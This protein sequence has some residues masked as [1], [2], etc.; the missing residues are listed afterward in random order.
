MI[1]IKIFI[2]CFLFF[3]VC[4]CFKGIS[5]NS[6][7]VKEHKRIISSNELT[8]GV[9]HTNEIIYNYMNQNLNHQNI[10]YIEMDLSFL[11]HSFSLTCHKSKSLT[12]GK[13]TLSNQVLHEQ[14][15]GKNLIGAINGDFF[16]IRNG[17][18]TCAN[19][20]NHEIYST[21]L[22]EEEELLRPCFAIQ[23][24]NFVDINYYCFTGKLTFTDKNNNKSE[25]NIDSINRNDYIEN[26]INLFNYKN[27][28]YSTIFLPKEKED[29]LII[30]IKP[31]NDNGEFIN[32]KKITGNIINIIYDPE[33]FYKISKDEIAIIAYDNKKQ[34]FS[35]L[36]KN[37]DVNIDLKFKRKNN[38]NSPKIKHLITGHEYL[39]YDEQIPDENYFSKTWN[40]S[41]VYSKNHR[42][43]LALTK[44]NTLI[45]LTVDKKHDFKGMSLP[46]LGAL[47]KSMDAY[48]AIN[49]DGG[50]STSMMIRE[51]GIHTLKN[52][53]LPKEDRHIANSIMIYNNLPYTTNIKE[54]YFHDSPQINRNESRRL[55]F[56]AY[57]INLNPIDIYLLPNLKLSSNVGTFDSNGVFFPFQGCCKGTITIEI[58]NILKTYPIEIL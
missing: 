52:I 17:I 45:A 51:L 19:I 6:K 9:R 33:N 56:I 8:L 18:P 14:K 38:P 29:A 50:G 13:D 37:M 39:L 40:K 20:S 26:T 4:L 23:D 24:D 57:D 5:I 10:N 32:E 22:N 15:K 42:T 44:R 46:D 28:E 36:Y 25:I 30:L 3:V 21:S 2:N 43:A 12:N 53:N 27:N 55:N 16:N 7:P 31:L 35:N 1:K 58:N 11:N 47:L 41:C 34:L 54:F 48:V 49:L